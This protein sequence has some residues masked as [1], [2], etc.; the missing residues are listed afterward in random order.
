LPIAANNMFTNDRARFDV[1]SRTFEESISSVSLSHSPQSVRDTNTATVPGAVYSP[2]P[3]TNNEP[4]ALCS[5]NLGFVQSLNTGWSMPARGKRNPNRLPPVPRF[6]WKRLD[7]SAMIPAR[8]MADSLLQSFF[9][10][11]H[12]FLP[13]FHRPTFEERYEKLWASS[14]PSK[15]PTP[16][17]RLGDDIFLSTLNV[18]FALGSLF[19]P[20]VPDEDRDTVSDEYYDRS[21][22]L[23]NFDICDYS[24]LSTVRLQLVTGLYLQT[25]PHSSRCWSVVGT[26]IRIAQDLGLHEDPSGHVQADQ[27]EVEMNRRLW[28]SCVTMDM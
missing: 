15:P 13:I 2:I 19:S 14:V 21:R 4:S 25:T 27:M 8:P 17:E 5:S 11:A 22:T 9:T 10:F 26:A 12:E 28:H 1:F 7:S 20:L 23:T 6:L 24:T 3:V 18:C 16:H